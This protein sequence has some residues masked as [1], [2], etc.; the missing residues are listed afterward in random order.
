MIV[1]LLM[2]MH[3]IQ[4]KLKQ[5]Y[6]RQNRSIR[7]R[8]IVAI[9]QPHTFTR[10]AALLDEFAAK[11]ETAADHVYLCDIFSSAREKVR[12]FNN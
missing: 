3:I 12:E 2:T 8:E 5:H 9:F 7:I 11:F 4:Q 10:T 6:N 1:L